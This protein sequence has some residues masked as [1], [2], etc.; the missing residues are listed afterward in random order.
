MH[1]MRTACGAVLLGLIAAGARAGPA[2]A[3][4]GSPT[5]KPVI[6]TQARVFS[7]LCP[8]IFV[9]IVVVGGLTLILRRWARKKRRDEAPADIVPTPPGS[10]LTLT[11]SQRDYQREIEDDR[12]LEKEEDDN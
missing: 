12:I 5:P 10:G 4:P 2:V 11:H 1:R 7:I 3:A 8:S 6:T 9:A